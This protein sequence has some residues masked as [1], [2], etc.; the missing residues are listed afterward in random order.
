MSSIANC[1]ITIEHVDI[2]KHTFG[3]YVI[4]LK[5]KVQGLN[6]I[7]YTEMTLNPKIFDTEAS[8]FGT[9]N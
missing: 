3:T 5:E 4:N 8:E 9:R 7:Q 2:D 6:Q 1:S